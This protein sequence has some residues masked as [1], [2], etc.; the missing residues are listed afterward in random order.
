MWKKLQK[1][2]NN[3]KKV[4]NKEFKVFKPYFT[5]KIT[6]NLRL[7]NFISVVSALISFIE[8]I[9][10]FT[11]SNKRKVSIKLLF[12]SEYSNL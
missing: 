12:I 11:V 3:I 4:I 10:Q 1:F 7:T 6:V 8:L 2:L 9:Q 5:I